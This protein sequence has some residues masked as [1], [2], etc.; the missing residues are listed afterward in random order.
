MKRNENPQKNPYKRVTK[1]GRKRDNKKKQ[2]AELHPVIDIESKSVLMLKAVK[3]TGNGDLSSKPKT[4][5]VCC[6]RH[7]KQTLP[8]NRKVKGSSYEKNE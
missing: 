4:N 6:F 3:K 2:Q 1:T 5:V 7:P 8:I